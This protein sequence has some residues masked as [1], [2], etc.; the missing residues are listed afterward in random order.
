MQA[1]FIFK[2]KTRSTIRANWVLGWIW[3]GIYIY[4]YTYTYIYIY[5]YIYLS[6]YIYLYLIQIHKHNHTHM[7]LLICVFVLFRG[8]T[9]VQYGPVCFEARTGWNSTC[10][11]R[12]RWEKLL[13]NHQSNQKRRTGQPF[14]E[15]IYTTYFWNFPK[16]IRPFLFGCARWMFK[17]G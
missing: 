15:I 4:I 3:G 12:L 9:W 10:A 1:K 2:K 14:T 13:R 7:F 16:Y 11:Q 17:V 6:I 8:T 5:V